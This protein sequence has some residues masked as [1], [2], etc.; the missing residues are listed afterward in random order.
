VPLRRNRLAA[1]LALLALA[2]QLLVPFAAR[3]QSSGA[4]FAATICSVG[5]APAAK[6][7][8]IPLPGHESGKAVKH[9]PLCSS[10][11][12]RTQAVIASAPP[13]LFVPSGAAQAPAVR[14]VAVFRSLVFSPARPRAPP[15]QS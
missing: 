1:C 7:P 15:V 14:P 4:V 2:L 11:A 10:G 5:G 8:G 9:C 12:D 3:A 13:V 6:S